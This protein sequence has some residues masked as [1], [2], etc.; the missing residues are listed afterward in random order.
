MQ[1]PRDVMNRLGW[2]VA[3]A[4]A[5]FCLMAAPPSAEAIAQLP[6]AVSR[7]VDFRQDVQPIL[8]AS[9]VKCHGRGKSKGGWKLDTREAFLQPGDSGPAVVV[10]RRARARTKARAAAAA[11]AVL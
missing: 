9:C 11:V 3:V 6:P 1:F 5:P 7:T 2:W 4:M 8:E 10:G